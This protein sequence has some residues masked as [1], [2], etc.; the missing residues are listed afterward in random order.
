MWIQKNYD[1]RYRV[2]SF[3]LILV[4]GVFAVGMYLLAPWYLDQDAF[5]VRPLLFGATPLLAVGCILWS[6]QPARWPPLILPILLI[7]FG[8]IGIFVQGD[9]PPRNTPT[10]WSDSY[11]ALGTLELLFWKLGVPMW[12]CCGFSVGLGLRRPLFRKGRIT[13]R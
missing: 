6:R 7:G 8:L 4:S 3:M 10:T 5:L 2:V 13:A 9:W 12:I 11:E 1:L